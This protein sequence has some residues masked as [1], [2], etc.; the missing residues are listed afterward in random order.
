MAEWVSHLIVADQVLKR[1]PM[2]C[3]H[4]FCVGNIAPDC[5]KANPGGKNFTPPRE[6]T[7]WMN[8]ERKDASDTKQ[9]CTEY[10]VNRLD[11]ISSKEELS[12]LLGYYSHL[13]TDAELQRTIRDS[14]RVHAAWE[15]ILNI[16]ELAKKA[17]D[18]PENWDSVKKLLDR[19]ERMK[20]FFAIERE[21]LDSHPDSGYFTEIVGLTEFPDYIDYLPHNA[22]PDKIK[23]MYDI[24]SAELGIYPYVAFTR[25]EYLGFLQRAED[26]V[27]A[28]ISEVVP[29]N[30]AYRLPELTDKCMLQEYVQE[31]YDNN[32]SG[33]SASMGLPV[34]EYNEWV[35]KIHRNASV[36]DTEWGR[37]LLYLCFEHDKLVGL[38]SIR[39]ELPEDLS[40]IYGDIGY[41]VRPSEREKGYATMMLHHALS[42]CKEKGLKKVVLGCYKDNVA[43]AATIKK[44]GGVLVCEN[45]NYN[46]GRI[47]QYYSIDL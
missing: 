37:S 8:G 44:N 19:R 16:P 20:D 45:E 47:S 31:H 46:E 41:G 23:I 40:N 13:I 11:K 21:Y 2:L 5:N 28:A 14:E 4:E 33:I 35:E 29:V 15:R 26:L 22:I 38:L 10:I 6:V 12:F 9:F 42:V 17:L 1:I 39:Y 7:H 18:L 27:V 30:M 32:E 43:S 34:S 3:R 25:E 24:P 36:G